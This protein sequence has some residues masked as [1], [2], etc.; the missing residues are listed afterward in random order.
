VAI[1]RCPMALWGT[2]VLHVS[3]ASLHLPGCLQKTSNIVSFPTLCALGMADSRLLSDEPLQ[4]HPDD[5]DR[6]SPNGAEKLHDNPHQRQQ[7]TLYAR[8]LEDWW[9]GELVAMLSSCALVV[10]LCVVLKKYDGQQV[11]S[12]G[13]WF[14]SGITL[15]TLVALLTTLA[16]AMALSTVQECLSQLKWLWYSGASRPLE[17]VET[18]DRASRGLLGS[19]Q[20]MWKLRSTPTASFGALLTLAHLALAPLAQQSLLSVSAPVV[21]PNARAAIPIVKSWRELDQQTQTTSNMPFS[22]DSISPGMKGAFLNGLFANANVTIDNVSPTCTTGNC[23]FPDYKSLAVCAMSA[24]VT[25]HLMDNSTKQ[26]M[27]HCLPGGFCASNKV[28]NPDDD[29]ILRATVTSAVTQA[30]KWATKNGQA[31]KYTSLSF[32][33]HSSPIG[34]FYIIYENVTKDASGKQDNRWAA[35]E[36]ALHWCAPAFS[37]KVTN[38]TATTSRYP[39]PFPPFNDESSYDI[40]NGAMSIDLSTHTTLQRYLNMSLSGSAYLRG[41]DSSADSD[42]TQKLVGFFGIGGG[43]VDIYATLTEAMAGLDAMLANTATSMTNYMRDWP[44]AK[45]VNGT[46]FVQQNVVKVRWAWIVA[47]IV[48]CA[49][50]LLFFVTVVVLCSLRRTVKPPLWKSSAVATLRCADPDLHRELGGSPGPMSLSGSVGK[51][52]VRLL[53]DG[54]GWLLVRDKGL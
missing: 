4:Q 1:G 19:V 6:G 37:T 35:I 18:Y 31:F 17:D 30:D 5:H 26:V 48:F 21:A 25:S 54:E 42:L 2:M 14:D 51:E 33:D 12:F 13:T 3:R 34:D 10:A 47:P 36:L 9:L 7:P 11:P 39:G 46:A 27:R 32:A 22:Y 44:N 45:V 8:W 41:V 16:V 53:R 24:D 49:A 52:N 15:G 23:T 38:G 28:P 43:D 40:A 50:S 29:P 20:L